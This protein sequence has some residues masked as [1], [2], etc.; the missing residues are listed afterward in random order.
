M[1]EER[2]E[3]ITE[4]LIFWFFS[5]RLKT[6]TPPRIDKNSINWSETSISLGDKHP[7]PFSYSTK[8]LTP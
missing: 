2:S 4:S 5:G 1:G 3:G 6:G 7:I 8:T